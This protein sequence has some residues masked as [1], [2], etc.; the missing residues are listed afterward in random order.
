MKLLVIVLVGIVVLAVI[1]KLTR[2]QKPKGWIQAAV[3]PGCG[4]TGQTSRYAGRCPKCNAPIGEQRGRGHGT[5]R[6]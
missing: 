3:C 6:G 5:G 2:R 4:W 1:W